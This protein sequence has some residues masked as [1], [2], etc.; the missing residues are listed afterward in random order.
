MHNERQLAIRLIACAAF[1][2]VVVLIVTMTAT[3]Q[4]ALSLHHGN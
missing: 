4:L 2:G 3:R 1:A